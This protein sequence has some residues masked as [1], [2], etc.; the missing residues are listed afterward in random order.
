MNFETESVYNQISSEY[1]EEEDDE[2]EEE[3]ERILMNTNVRSCE[4][5]RAI[6]IIIV[7]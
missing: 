5:V 2:E 6:I 7:M 3:A 1:L 4:K